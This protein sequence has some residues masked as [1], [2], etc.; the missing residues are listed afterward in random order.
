[1]RDFPTK[2]C[3]RSFPK[4]LNG[5]T[6]PKYCLV[7]T[8][9]QLEQE[10]RMKRASDGRKNKPFC[11]RK[12]SSGC[13]HGPPLTC[14]NSRR[15]STKN[16]ITGHVSNV[17]LMK[18]DT[19]F[20]PAVTGNGVAGLLDLLNRDNT[21]QPSMRSSESGCEY[22]GYC[23]GRDNLVQR[24]EIRTTTTVGHL[25]RSRLTDSTSVDFPRNSR[26]GTVPGVGAHDRARS[27]RAFETTGW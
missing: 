12:T 14:I 6:G 20:V 7:Q 24:E 3:S 1:M 21:G 9:P 13:T 8:S 4:Y 15:R 27:I 22:R 16:P 19:R 23:R 18:D 17:G 2:I 5:L 25:P 11:P 10:P 26:H